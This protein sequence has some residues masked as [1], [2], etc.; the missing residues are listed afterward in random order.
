MQQSL[1]PRLQQIL[2]VYWSAIGKLTETG[3]STALRK[4]RRQRF[5]AIDGKYH[6]LEKNPKTILELEKR[7]AK[8]EF[9]TIYYS[10]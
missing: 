3:K 7:R 4:L 1:I 10:G 9:F 6:T 2:A 5:K 8:P